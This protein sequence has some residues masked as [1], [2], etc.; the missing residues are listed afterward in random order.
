MRSL[1]NTWMRR[2][3]P[4]VSFLTTESTRRSMTPKA[5]APPQSMGLTIVEKSSGFTWPPVGTQMDSSGPSNHHIRRSNEGQRKACPVLQS[6]IGH[7]HLERYYARRS[8]R[9]QDYRSAN[10]RLPTLILHRASN[11]APRDPTT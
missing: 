5:S 7:H 2:A 4:T 9:T 8:R 3:S 11:F 6:R 10:L 1:G